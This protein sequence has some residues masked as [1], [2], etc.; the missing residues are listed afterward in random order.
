MTHDV[1]QELVERM[2]R[3]RGV[4]GKIAR[5]TG[6][7]KDEVKDEVD[8]DVVEILRKFKKMQD[9]HDRENWLKRNGGS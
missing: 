6:Y 1:F 3:R 7:H 4:D 8:P 2:K 5:Y 9:D